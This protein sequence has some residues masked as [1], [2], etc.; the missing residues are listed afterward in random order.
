MGRVDGKQGKGEGRDK[1]GD[2]QGQSFG[3]PKI[4][5]KGGKRMGKMDDGDGR[6]P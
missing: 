1:G 2:R 3:D 4:A 6:N 5:W